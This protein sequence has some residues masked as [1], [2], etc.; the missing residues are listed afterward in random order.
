M[1]E[2]LGGLSDSIEN[3]LPSGGFFYQKKCNAQRGEKRFRSFQNSLFSRIQ[4]AVHFA[5]RAVENRLFV[6]ISALRESGFGGSPICIKSKAK[7]YR[8]R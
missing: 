5:E 2:V 7:T 3:H 4:R 1:F 6:V 8:R